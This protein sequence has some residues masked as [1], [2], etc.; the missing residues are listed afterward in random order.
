MS[1]IEAIETIRKAGPNARCNCNAYELAKR[2]GGHPGD[3]Q[4]EIGVTNGWGWAD[5]VLAAHLRA[6]MGGNPY[7]YVAYDLIRDE[8][9]AACDAVERGEPDADAVLRELLS[10]FRDALTD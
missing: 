5:V 2:F 6:G 9:P 10:R 4:V 8:W 7:E 1:V 3:V